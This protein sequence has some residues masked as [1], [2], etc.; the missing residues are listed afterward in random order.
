M[1][2][3]AV[4]SLRWARSIFRPLEQ[5]ARTMQRRGGRRAARPRGA[6]PSGDEIG[7]W[8]APGPPARHH[9]RQAARCSA[10]TPSWT[11]R[12][13]SARA[14]GRRAG[15]S[16]CASEKLAAVGQL[17]ASIAHEVNNPIAVIQGNLDLLRELLGAAAG[18]RRPS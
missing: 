3:A 11:P 12:W 8:P 1:I 6:V 15:S 9:R 10:G 4:V 16:W 17:T 18:R 2:G 13:P 14:T 5:M 7:R